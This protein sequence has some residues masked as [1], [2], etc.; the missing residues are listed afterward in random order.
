MS[1]IIS[2]IKI[3]RPFH[4]MLFLIGFVILIN[5]FVQ[6]AVPLVTKLIVDEIERQLTEGS[7]NIERLTYFIGIAFGLSVAGTLFESINQRLGDYTN[8]RIG[9]YLTERFYQKIFTLSQHYFDSQLSGK[10]VNQLNRGIINLQ[11]FMSASTNFIVPALVQSIFVIA[12]LW[13][14]SVPIALLAL[15]IFPVYIIISHY[16]TKKWG[17]GE[18]KKNV[19][20]DRTRGRIQEVISNIKLVR[21][22]NAHDHEQAFV[23]D[24]LKK[25]VSIYDTQSTTYHILNFARNFGLETVLMV[26]SVIVFRQTY[27]GILTLGEMVLI[28]QLL[29]RIRWPL[30][31]MSMILE[32]VQRAE[33]GSREY[34]HILSLEPA[35]HPSRKKKTVRIPRPSIEFRDV[36]YAYEQGE[37][38]LHDVNFTLKYGQTIALVGH[39]GAGKTTIVNLILKFY[40]PTSGSITIGGKEYP[41]LSHQDIR[42]HL[43][44]VFQ[45]SELFSTTVRENVAYG[46]P[47]ATDAEI[48][49]ALKKAHAYDFVMKFT[50]GLETEIGERGVKLSGGQKQRI[51]IG[52]AI[53]HNAPILILDEATSSL[54]AKSEKLVQDALDVLMKNKL[55]IIIAHRF[56]TIQNADRVLVV[57][58]GMVVDN[59]TPQNLARKKGTFSELLDY[60]VKGNQKLLEQYGLR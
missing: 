40:V 20:E 26:I 18:V 48:I 21:T 15:S 54:D 27:Q 57:E 53:L 1:N 37:T 12:V 50:D 46:K 42:D 22:F 16:S 2:V 10:I 55:V 38:V 59:D 45:D 6:M 3:A 58:H 49:G 39:S 51:Q 4:R 52:R 23:S 14:Y 33:A 47:D 8:S 28:L 13:Y 19:I 60:Q 32:R 24:N 25:S 43:S 9:K 44:L 30:F 34:F 7:G 11:D 29:V 31:A 5:A 35:E 17:E 56:S 41:K 36:S